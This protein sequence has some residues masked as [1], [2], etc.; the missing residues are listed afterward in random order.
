MKR[1]LGFAEENQ[2]TEKKNSNRIL[3]SSKIIINIVLLID[4]ARIFIF[5]DTRR[6]FLSSQFLFIM[7]RILIYELGIWGFILKI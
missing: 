3:I 7:G 1:G 6:L 2:D 5:Q 4:Q